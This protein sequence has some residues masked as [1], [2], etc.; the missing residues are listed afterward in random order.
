MPWPTASPGAGLPLKFTYLCSMNAQDKE[1]HK[2]G[3]DFT[4]SLLIFHNACFPD[5]RLRGEE[6]E[7]G[8]CLGLPLIGTWQCFSRVAHQFGAVLLMRSLGWDVF[9]ALTNNCLKMCLELLSDINDGCTHQLCRRLYGS[10][11]AW[12]PP[13]E[14]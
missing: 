2:Q 11:S 8:L 10:S 5:T 1:T 6:R 9:G 14:G 3:R 13:N 12:V 7:G 4:T